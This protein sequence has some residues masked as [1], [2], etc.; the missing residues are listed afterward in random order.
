MAMTT[1][2]DTAP[3]HPFHGSYHDTEYGFPSADEA[4]LF[5]RL[6]LEINQAGLSW[7]TVLRKRA[8]F[9]AAFEGFDVDRVAGGYSTE[10]LAQ[11]AC[12]NGRW[13][14]H[15]SGTPTIKAVVRPGQLC[16]PP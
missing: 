4:V 6:V 16:Q 2:C 13:G 11:Q 7:L 5:E 3:G 8:A 10:V 14:P 12:A 1:Y 15:R 9:K